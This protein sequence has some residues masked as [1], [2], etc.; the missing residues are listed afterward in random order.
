[1]RVAIA[2]TAAVAAVCLVAGCRSTDL[3]RAD[4]VVVLE[5]EPPAP[6]WQA[7]LHP[8][9]AARLGR[10]DEAWD[11]ALALADQPRT[12]RRLAAEGTLL[13]PDAALSRATPPPGT[14][15]CRTFTFPVPA[16]GRPAFTV[17]GPHFCYVGVEG[18]LLSLTR[19]TGP[20]RPGGYL[21]EDGDSRL[22]FIG[23]LAIGRERVPPAYG[24][25]RERDSVGLVERVGPFRYRL[26][27]PWPTEGAILEV[28]ELT[29]VVQ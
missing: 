16:R 10:I 27:V 5:E 2:L 3:S 19:Q 18:A 17:Q 9:D 20:R 11:W 6:A 4:A 22:V 15:R 29:P 8:D 13:Q 7:I 1:M 24:A 12:R 14:Y 25:D 26:V 21:Y 23:A 28:Y